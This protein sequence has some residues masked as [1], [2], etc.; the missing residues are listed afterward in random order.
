[1]KAKPNPKPKKRK[2]IFTG[3][4]QPVHVRTYVQGNFREGVDYVFD[5][6]CGMNGI[7]ILVEAE[8]AAGRVVTLR[9]LEPADVLYSR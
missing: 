7:N 9:N 3:F 6:A 5:R 4:V 1:M 2:I 8:L